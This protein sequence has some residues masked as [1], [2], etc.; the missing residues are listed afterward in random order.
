[1]TTA[2]HV[3]E[4]ALA[5]W[6]D[7]TDGSV[8]GASV[9]QHLLTCPDCRA[10]VPADPVAD[11]V[12]VRVQDAIE[13][14][15]PKLLERLLRSAGLPSPDARIV[16]ASPAFRG[17]WLVGMAALLLFV[18]VAGSFGNAR[19]QWA[20]LLIAPLVPALA[21]ALGYDPELDEQLEAECATPYSRLRLV[22][23]R[24]AA[25]LLVGIPSMVLASLALPGSIA[26]WW[27]APAAGCTAVVLAL[28][29]WTTPLNSVGTVGTAWLLVVGSTFR[30][31]T[32]TDI[33][34]E[35]W[36]ATYLAVGVVALLVMVLRRGRM[37][38]VAR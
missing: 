8:S 3:D 13:V 38:W 12:W 17:A 7:G 37:A 23:L 14:P 1:M 21:V 11:A 29:T 30:T 26:F 24:S 35:E 5:R 6:V 32:P 16:A 18:T 20:F 19:G 31:H 2:W 22:L 10:L 15:R 28:S 25:L 33:L 34:D 4:T 9:E 27:L 36:V